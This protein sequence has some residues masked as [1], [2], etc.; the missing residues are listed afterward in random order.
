MFDARV[1]F[2]AALLQANGAIAEI[3]P[4]CVLDF[5]VHEQYQRQGVGKTL[6]EVRTAVH[7]APAAAAKPAQQ[8][9][10]LL[11]TLAGSSSS[12]Q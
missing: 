10:Q 9:H 12:S 3:E 7:G 8:L 5:Y 1:L 6:F 11:C 2:V 4:L